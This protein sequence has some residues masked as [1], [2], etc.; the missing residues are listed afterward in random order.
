MSEKST[1]KTTVKTYESGAAEDGG[2]GVAVS[3]DS[4]VCRHA[5][6]CVR[7]LP[8][9][10]DTGRRP[11]ITPGAADPE[12]VAEVVRRCPTGALTYRF[13]DGRGEEPERP[14]S[15][16]AEP[17]G[18]LLVRGELRIGVGEA[19]RETNRAMLCG[20]GATAEPP[21]CDRSGTCG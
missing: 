19:A 11:W 8:E 10:F 14:T 1:V 16:V 4:A 9:V 20:C 21:Y 2:V 5:A 17:D 18:R 13:S 7:G 15:V 6:E 3:F 12:R